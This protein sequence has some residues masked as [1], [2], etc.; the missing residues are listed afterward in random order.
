MNIIALQLKRSFK[1][2]C[3]AGLL[4]LTSGLTLAVELSNFPVVTSTATS[5]RP[6]LMFVLDDSGSMGW[7]FMPDYV[8]SENLCRDSSLTNPWN[9]TKCVTMDP[10]YFAAEFNGIYY[11]PSLDYKPPAKADGTSWP[12]QVRTVAGV[13]VWDQVE[14]NPFSPSGV[15]NIATHYQDQS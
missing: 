13:P 12:D 10:P 2:Y 3:A 6:N 7:A 9:K 14:N 1:R 8:A 4:T 15:I 11:N 5:V